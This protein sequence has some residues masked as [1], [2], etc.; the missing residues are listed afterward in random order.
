[1]FDRLMRFH[2]AGAVALIDA[3]GMS[4][5]ALVVELERSALVYI[6]PLIGKF[7]AGYHSAT[8]FRMSSL[9]FQKN[10]SVMVAEEIEAPTGRAEVSKSSATSSVQ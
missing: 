3:I 7:E 4:F 10:A 9:F 2:V 1:M 8:K 5:Q 6:A